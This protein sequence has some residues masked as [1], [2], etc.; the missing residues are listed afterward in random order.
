MITIKYLRKVYISQKEDIYRRNC[1][2]CQSFWLSISSLATQA[3]F[4]NRS[5]LEV[6]Y[7]KQKYTYKHVRCGS[8]HSNQIKSKSFI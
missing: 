7:N 2:E 5:C 8:C 3:N 1:Q 4:S 6:A